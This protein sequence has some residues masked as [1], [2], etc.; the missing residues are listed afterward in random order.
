MK[1]LF[2]L[3]VFSILVLFSCGQAPERPENNA[4]IKD[5]AGQS[6]DNKLYNYY[7][8]F[9]SRSDGKALKGCPEK[10]LY[11][12]SVEFISNIITGDKAL[13]NS[14]LL[15]SSLTNE[16]D[17]SEGFIY[18]R[19]GAVF[20]KL[21]DYQEAYKYINTAILMG[22]KNPELY[23]YKAML[24]YYYKRD[25]TGAENYLAKLDGTVSFLNKQDIEYLK[26]CLKC[27]KSDF[28]NAYL[29][30]MSA[31]EIDPGRFFIYY[32][33]LPYF[34]R[35]DILGKLDGY[36]KESFK[37]LVSLSN[38]NYRLKA[39]REL[40]TFNRL[41]NRETLYIPFNLPEYYDY[42]TNLVYLFSG[43][44]PLTEKR[45]SRDVI[46]PLQEKRKTP[47]DLVYS[48]VYEEYADSDNGSSIFLQEGIVKLVDMRPFPFPNSYP[49]PH[50]ITVSNVILLL[51]PTNCF[52]LI[53]NSNSMDSSKI[54]ITS[55]A[56]NE[57][58]ITN[59]GYDYYFATSIFSLGGDK[60][61]DFVTLG[62]T[63]SN[64]VVVNLFYPV[65]KKLET[66]SFS[67]KRH[68]SA[69]VIQD[70]KGSGKPELILLDDD[71]Y[72]LGT[73]KN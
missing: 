44:Y 64:R 73:G 58:Y 46:S 60:T 14:V 24:L 2:V 11:A 54:S 55:N 37:Y 31:K 9:R 56:R 26:A 53:S 65:Q 39:Y 69:F 17:V 38:S 30:F 36:I 71:V 22:V 23:Y 21:R 5:N 41:Q 68:D 59:C 18:Q 12:L 27:E 7:I 29:L 4:R 40:I 57:L 45:K 49:V 67:L 15:Y 52:D 72:I 43:G 6:L 61:W 33:I 20:F 25:Y 10:L 8:A 63:A 48:P 13:S 3:S 34:I 28:E 47:R 62:I 70:L 50:L 66:F 42:S 16:P 19:I 35:S 51:S 32:D 1:S